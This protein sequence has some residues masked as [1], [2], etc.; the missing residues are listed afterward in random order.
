MVHIY[1]DYSQR[2]ATPPTHASAIKSRG[3]WIPIAWPH[4]GLAKD[5][6]SGVPL[7]DLYRKEGLNL[8]T[9]KFSNPPGPNQKEGHRVDRGLRSELSKCGTEW[10]PEGS[11]FTGIARIGYQ[12]AVNTT[13]KTVKSLK[14]RMIV[15]LR[16]DMPYNRYG[17]LI[18]CP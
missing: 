17:S 10:R 12:S 11:R 3:D 18:L 5:K 9:E 2:G 15:F 7:A 13:E 16:Q 1:S 14:S 6:G 8:L 4:D